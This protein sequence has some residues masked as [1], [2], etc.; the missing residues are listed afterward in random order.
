[1]TQC[2]KHRLEQMQKA[3]PSIKVTDDAK[4]GFPHGVRVT[5]KSGKFIAWF[6]KVPKRCAC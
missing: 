1:M 5:D 3:N 4:T 2:N 6:A